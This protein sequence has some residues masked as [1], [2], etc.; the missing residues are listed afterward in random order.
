MDIFVFA[1]AYMSVVRL[2][3]EIVV[4]L[5]PLWALREDLRSFFRGPLKSS[6]FNGE[7]VK[8]PYS[9]GTRLKLTSGEVHWLGP[10][11][12]GEQLPLLSS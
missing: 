11:W 6:W 3:W 9:E 12:E 8:F 4:G 7:V 10:F 5:R 1:R 2:P